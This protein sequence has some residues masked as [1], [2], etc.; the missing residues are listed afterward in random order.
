MTDNVS[1]NFVSQSLASVSLVSM[2]HHM[3]TPQD[4]FDIACYSQCEDFP[5]IAS[6]K[7]MQNFDRFALCKILIDSSQEKWLYLLI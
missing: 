4:K 7:Y 5:N 6:R 1:V 2:K 3:S